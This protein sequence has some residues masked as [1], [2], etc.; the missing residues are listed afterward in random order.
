V[1]KLGKCRNGATTDPGH[2]WNIRG[3]AYLTE[4]SSSA[5]FGRCSLTELQA[6]LTEASLPN[7][8]GVRDARLDI[9]MNGMHL[10]LLAGHGALPVELSAPVLARLWVPSTCSSPEDLTSCESHGPGFTGLAHLTGSPQPV[11]CS[12]SFRS[13]ICFLHWSRGR[14]AISMIPINGQR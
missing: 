2:A 10:P 14:P 12:C 8:P 1:D 7:L 4:T 5:E 13:A 3:K 9:Q 11:S 6:Y